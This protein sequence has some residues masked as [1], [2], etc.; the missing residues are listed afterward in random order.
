MQEL[1]A[2][3]GYHEKAESTSLTCIITLKKTKNNYKPL[4]TEKIT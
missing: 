2:L 3:K 4:Q 1:V